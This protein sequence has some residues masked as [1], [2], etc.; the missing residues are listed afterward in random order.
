MLAR[1]SPKRASDYASDRVY[2]GVRRLDANKAKRGREAIL[3][4]L[5]AMRAPRGDQSSSES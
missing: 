3:K 1:K 5:E 4:S 2:D